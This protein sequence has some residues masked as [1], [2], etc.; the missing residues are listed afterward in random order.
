MNDERIQMMKQHVETIAQDIEPPIGF[1]IGDDT[2][3]PKTGKK[4]AGFGLNH[5]TVHDDVIAS[6]SIVT[7]LY[8]FQGFSFPFYPSLY[9]SETYC[10]EHKEIFKTK[11]DLLEEQILKAPLPG[12]VRTIGLFDA[13]YFNN[14]V[15]NACH[16]R[17]IEAMGRLKENRRALVSF[18]NPEGTRLDSWFDFLRSH[19]THP[20]KQIKVRDNQDSKHQLWVYHW[21]GFIK[22]LGMVQVLILSERIRGK[23]IT[24]FFIATTD[25]NLSPEQII[26]FYFKRWAIETFFWTVKERMGFNDYQV[27]PEQSAKRHW[28]LVFLAH[29]Y[30]VTTRHASTAMKNKT[31][32]DFQR[33]EQRENFKTLIAEIVST[34]TSSFNG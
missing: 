22:N 24:P 8:H 7:T 25:L 27:R 34:E 4:M 11:N 32:G 9:K 16:E 30:L 12:N 33:L 5:S 29:S 15:I 3:N 23:N 6:Q 1:L 20:F 18:H 2:T 31:L 19:K 10:E 28:L 14:Q 13:F 21:T 26:E 17:H